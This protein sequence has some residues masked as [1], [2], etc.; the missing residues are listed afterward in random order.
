MNA[1]LGIQLQLAQRL[2]G[3][4]RGVAALEFAL[5]LPFMLTLYIGIAEISKGYMASQRMTLVARTLAD[6]VAQQGQ[7][8]QP[9]PGCTLSS[10]SVTFSDS[11]LSTIFGA[12]QAIMS[13]YDTNTAN[14]GILKMTISQ[15][16]VSLKSDGTCCQAKTDWT[17]ASTGATKRPCQVLTAA[18]VKPVSMTTI[19]TGYVSTNSPLANNLKSKTDTTPLII[20]DVTYAYTPFGGKLSFKLFNWKS[21]DTLNMAQTQYM[22]PRTSAAAPSKLNYSGSTGTDC[23]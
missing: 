11:C 23:P 19:P 10:G 21:P 8:Q 17:Y 9:A 4:K 14:S 15:I 6:L 3:D 20:S 13:P 5:I 7:A 1:L 22:T 18:D 16:L 2:R 12:A